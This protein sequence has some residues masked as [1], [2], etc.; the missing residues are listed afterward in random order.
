MEVKELSAV[1]DG[2]LKDSFIKYMPRVHLDE[3]KRMATHTANRQLLQVA[4]CK[5]T[6][7]HVQSLPCDAA[8]T[9]VGDL[10]LFF[11]MSLSLHK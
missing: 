3:G 7:E 5:A 1:A 2:H 10:R 9:L 11:L 4:N 8:A 6:L